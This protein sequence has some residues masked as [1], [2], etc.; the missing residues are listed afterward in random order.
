MMT[1]QGERERKTA[2]RENDAR[3]AREEMAWG[4]EPG[5]A[6]KEGSLKGA[7]EA[8]QKE[9]NTTITTAIGAG[10]GLKRHA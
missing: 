6:L 2:D 3:K 10:G 8:V 9:E 5:M 1:S 4:R 7:G